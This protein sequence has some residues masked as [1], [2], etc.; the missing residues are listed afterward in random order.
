M[1]VLWERVMWKMFVKYGNVLREM[2]LNFWFF[3]EN[4]LFFYNYVKMLE[5]IYKCENRNNMK[6]KIL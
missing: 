1:I 6:N 2:V 5:Y 4:K 3:S